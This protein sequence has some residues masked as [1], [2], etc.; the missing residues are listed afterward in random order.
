MLNFFLNHE[1]HLP[2]DANR[3]METVV[4]VH[5]L[6]SSLRTFDPLLGKLPA[7][8][9]VVT[10]DQRGHGKSPAR[11]E[12]YSSAAMA[13]DLKQLVDELK[14]GKFHLLGHSMGGRTA[15]AY[16]GLFP[17]DLKSAIIEDMGMEVRREEGPEE[18]QRILAKYQKIYREWRDHPLVFS[19]RQAV[20][21]VL[22]PLFS[23]ADSLVDSKVTDL[24]DGLVRL[25]FNP[26]VA[27]LYGYQGNLDDL[28][29]G[30]VSSSVKVPLTFLV[31]DAKVGS[32][33]NERSRAYIK[34]HTPWAKEHYFSG[35]WHNIHKSQTDA[36]VAVLRTIISD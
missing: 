34:K 22:R 12:D 20:R 28:S 36:F 18:G 7:H 15:L 14:L 19:S 21:E 4:M 9:K 35:A 32:A 8:W 30:L 10:V 13:R 5:G 26:G 25:E 27:A 23:Y 17:A 11:G 16:A 2:R 24:A 29:Q 33:M 31:A 6:Q 3:P 1:I